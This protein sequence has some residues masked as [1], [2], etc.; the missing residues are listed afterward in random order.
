M[1]RDCIIRISLIALYVMLMLV[2]C[3]KTDNLLSLELPSPDPN[4]VSIDK[5]ILKASS[6]VKSKGLLPQTKGTPNEIK[7]V[8]TIRDSEELPIVHVINFESG[9]FTL[10]SADDRI[11]P[12]LAFSEKGSFPS[13]K[14]EYPLGLN[15]WMEMIAKKI[16]FNRNNNI[17]Q[18]AIIKHLWDRTSDELIPTKSVPIDT[19]LTPPNVENRQ[20]GPLLST[21]WHQ[22]YPYNYDLPTVS[23]NGSSRTAYVGCGPLSI[24]QIMRYHEFPNSFLWNQMPNMTTTPSSAISDLIYDIMCVH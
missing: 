16:Q 1:I 17:Q 18:S 7:E 8:F 11:D 13:S 2:S 12:V 5:A 21:L 24:A 14:K 9:G 22:L 19:T 4:S 6:F 15:I 10:I 20:I 3:S 23:Y